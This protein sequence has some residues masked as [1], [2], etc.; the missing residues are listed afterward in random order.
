M[1]NHAEETVTVQFETEE[2]NTEEVASVGQETESF[3]DL[4][5]KPIAATH[6]SKGNGRPGVCSLVNADGNS[7][8]FTI[9]A[10]VMEQIGFPEQIQIGVNEKG[11]AVG[12]KLPNN[13]T[14]F[15]LKQSGTKAV[16]YSSELVKELTSLFDLDFSERTS[17]TFYEVTY[18]NYKDAVIAVFPLEK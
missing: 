16:V 11:F 10:K 18:L 3:E 1:T 6:E 4:N 2:L 8:R 17:I 12:A 5:F 14:C 13:E 9:S 7:K 15:T